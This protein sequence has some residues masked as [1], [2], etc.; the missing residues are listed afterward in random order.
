MDMVKELKKHANNIMKDKKTKEKIGD[1]IEN[2]L[3]SIKNQVKDHNKKEFLDKAIKAVD[4]AT[5]S[6]KKSNNK[7][8][9]QKSKVTSKT[10]KTNKTNKTSK[11]NKTNKTSKKTK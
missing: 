3:K 11:T 7:N 5:T 6:K 1:T 9:N 2:G 10:N 4:A 8:T